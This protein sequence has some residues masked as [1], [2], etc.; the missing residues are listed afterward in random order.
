MSCSLGIYTMY[1]MTASLDAFMSNESDIFIIHLDS[2]VYTCLPEANLYASYCKISF[3]LKVFLC[4]QCVV[5]PENM[6]NSI[7][8]Q[9]KDVQECMYTPSA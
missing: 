8:C 6:N 4:S 7:Y 3:R 9:S 2:L 5:Y 1:K